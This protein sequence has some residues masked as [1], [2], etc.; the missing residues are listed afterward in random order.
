MRRLAGRDLGT[1][2]VSDIKYLKETGDPGYRDALRALVGET[3]I[4][5]DRQMIAQAEEIFEDGEGNRKPV[6]GIL[7]SLAGRNLDVIGDRI[8]DGGYINSAGPR[9][10]ARGEFHAELGVHPF[11]MKQ[12][13]VPHRP[14]DVAGWKDDPAMAAYLDPDN[15]SPGNNAKMLRAVEMGLAASRGDRQAV[16]DAQKRYDF[17]PAEVEEFLAGARIGGSKFGSS[18]KYQGL[19]ADRQEVLLDPE[20]NLVQG[21]PEEQKFYNDRER[22]LTRSWLE[23]GGTSF[24][25]AGSDIGI[26]GKDYQMEHDQ[27]FTR[28]NP[29]GLAEV[30]V[31]R[32]G[33]YERYENADKND[34]DP[35]D[36]YQMQRLAYLAAQE[37]INVKGVFKKDNVQE[38][39]GAMIDEVNP[40]QVVGDRRNRNYKV[41]NFPERAAQN[42][43]LVQEAMRP[44]QRKAGKIFA[45]E[46]STVSVSKD[47]QTININA[48]G[49]D[50]DTYIY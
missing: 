49:S 47:G 17:T 4:L 27:A 30:E 34:L 12:G 13:G 16:I 21:S 44:V 15:A 6:Q 2:D 20:L 38:A 31:N 40:A 29:S 19:S 1:L 33:F 8:A 18:I 9:A 26:P 37:G 36:Y 48:Y 43:R 50:A 39:L 28:M 14:M 23:G 11:V 10:L 25:D 35:T 32:P 3:D 24:L 7:Q 45:P 41:E 22:A 42:E 46:D 5:S